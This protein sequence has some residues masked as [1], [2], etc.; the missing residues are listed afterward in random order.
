MHNGKILGRDNGALYIINFNI[1]NKGN[2]CSIPHFH[3]S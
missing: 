2:L 1:L 3:M